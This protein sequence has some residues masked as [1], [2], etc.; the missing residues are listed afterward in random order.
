MTIY[1]SAQGRINFSQ[2]PQ[3]SYSLIGR[4][5]LRYKDYF[6]QEFQIYCLQC[7]NQ[8]ES[9]T[10]QNKKY[11]YIP[12]LLLKCPHKMLHKVKW[13]TQVGEQSPS[14]EEPC[15]F[16]SDPSPSALNLYKVRNILYFLNTCFLQFVSIILEETYSF[17]T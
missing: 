1:Y 7:T 8:R 4:C 5:I 12:R 17:I 10:Y 16:S 11:K 13:C 9:I 3:Y 6:S 14:G 15:W 2:K